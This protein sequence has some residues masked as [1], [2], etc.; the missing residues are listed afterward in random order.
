MAESCVLKIAGV[1]LSNICGVELTEAGIGVIVGGSTFKVQFPVGHRR[2]RFV[3][4]LGFNRNDEFRVSFGFGFTGRFQRGLFC[5]RFSSAFAFNDGFVTGIE[6]I[7]LLI[8]EN[9]VEEEVISYLL[10]L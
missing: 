9:V 7:L 8:A 1:F 3:V 2:D 4:L 10:S 6:V 5:A